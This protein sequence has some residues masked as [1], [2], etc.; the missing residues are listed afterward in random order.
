M[1]VVKGNKPHKSESIQRPCS[2][3][4]TARRGHVTATNDT[5]VQKSSL[6]RRRPGRDH[7]SERA[8]PNRWHGKVNGRMQIDCLLTNT[9]LYGN[10]A[11]KTK[12]VYNTWEKC[13]TSDEDLHRDWCR[14]PGVLVG[15][16]PG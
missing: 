13:S 5:E 2:V 3:H 1:M 16:D 9:Y 4:V 6:G 14:H 8:I 11:L 12:V 10:K 15:K 7:H